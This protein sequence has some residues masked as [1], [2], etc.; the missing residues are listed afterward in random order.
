MDYYHKIK[1]KKQLKISVNCNSNKIP[2]IQKITNPQ[3]HDITVCK[4]LVKELGFTLKK[5]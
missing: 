5:I 1:N 3:V 2:N 4:K